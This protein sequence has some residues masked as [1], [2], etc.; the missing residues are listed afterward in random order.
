[1]KLAN[2]IRLLRSVKG[3]SQSY[4]ADRLNISQ[5]AYSK[6]EHRAEKC[7]LVTLA[8][9]ASVLEVS[10]VFLIDTNNDKFTEQKKGD[11]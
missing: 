5:A 6:I 1:M 9:L 2:R 8:K 3:F 4:V 7:S 10:T 11:I